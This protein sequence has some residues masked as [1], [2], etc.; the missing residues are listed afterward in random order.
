MLL[1][2]LSLLIE[3]F[4]VTLTIAIMFWSLFLV[5]YI[6]TPLDELVALHGLRWDDTREEILRLWRL[7]R[8]VWLVLY[9]LVLVETFLLRVCIGACVLLLDLPDFWCRNDRLLEDACGRNML[10]QSR[11]IMLLVRGPKKAFNLLLLIIENHG[12]SMDNTSR[13]RLCLVIAPKTRQHALWKSNSSIQKLQ[14][15]LQN[16]PFSNSCFK[17]TFFSP[18][19]C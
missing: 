14:K 12:P 15:A 17:S 4:F 7:V 13:L 5:L 18:H 19:P 6:W 11:V 1:L 3:L 10:S 8:N 2:L 9:L 16:P